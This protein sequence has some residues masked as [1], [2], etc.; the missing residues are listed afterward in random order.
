MSGDG[1]RA[2]LEVTRGPSQGSAV[3]LLFASVC[4]GSDPFGGPYVHRWELS[5]PAMLANHFLVE[6][7]KGAC[8]RVLRFKDGGLVLNGERVGDRAAALRD[9]DRIEVGETEVLYRIPPQAVRRIRSALAI[10]EHL[11]SLPADDQQA[12][13]EGCGSLLQRDEVFELGLLLRRERLTSPLGVLE[14]PGF[15][16]ATLGKLI[17]LQGETRSRELVDRVVERLGPRIRRWFES[18]PLCAPLAQDV[19]DLVNTVVAVVMEALTGKASGFVPG[20]PVWTYVQGVCH[21]VWSAHLRARRRLQPQPHVEKAEPAVEPEGGDPLEEAE[22]RARLTE[23]FRRWQA[24]YPERAEMVPLMVQGLNKVQIAEALGRDR[25]T[26]A[27]WL[28]ELRAGLSKLPGLTHEQRASMAGSF[29]DDDEHEL[30][31]ECLERALRDE[32][33]DPA[34]RASY[35]LE[36]ARSRIKLGQADRA[37]SDLDDLI[38]EPA[39]PNLAALAGA[40]LVRGELLRSRGDHAAAVRDFER[41]LSMERAPS[42]SLSILLIDSLLAA[43]RP[44]DAIARLEQLTA[45]PARGSGPWSPDTVEAA[46]RVVADLV[47]RCVAER[48]RGSRPSG[49]PLAVLE[50][51]ARLL[52]S[53]AQ[54]TSDYIEVQM[55]RGELALS[56]GLPELVVEAFT[57]LLRHDRATIEWVR[58][59]LYREYA[60]SQAGGTAWRSLQLAARV[61]PPQDPMLV[62]MRDELQVS[63]PVQELPGPRT[64]SQEEAAALIARICTKRPVPPTKGRKKWRWWLSA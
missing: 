11:G 28:T 25:G 64:I 13:L 1:P 5:E 24:R 33:A 48:Q 47:R 23:Y 18:Q 31:I 14:T 61:L 55:L 9:G 46:R 38:R 12:V 50:S 21:N 41:R 62:R 49:S 36:R 57:A 37:L 59:R 35:R 8:H 63:H 6:L 54:T 58:G 19:G 26:I 51:L 3:E 22:G 45:E 52:G 40:L 32:R 30:A 7:G 44:Q 4:A 10:E 53:D 17:Q 42:A 56:D 34:A 2:R 29:A 43:N 27:R 39:P 16:T 15:G 20:M 60:A